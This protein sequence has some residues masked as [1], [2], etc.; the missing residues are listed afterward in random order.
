MPDTRLRTPLHGALDRS[1]FM[2][3]TSEY[4][5][6]DL[7]ALG[8]IENLRSMGDH[9]FLLSY[10]ALNARREKN[11]RLAHPGSVGAG[12]DNP[13]DPQSQLT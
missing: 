10:S 1:Y 8:K 5:P 13:Q 6:A 7:V 4:R 9:C 3:S 11:L 2:P 12:P